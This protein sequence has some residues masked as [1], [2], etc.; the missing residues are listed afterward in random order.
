MSQDRHP[1]EL[2]LN[3]PA[4]I[5]S[6]IMF[7]WMTPLFSKAGRGPLELEDIY[8]V[9]CFDENA[10]QTDVVEK[11]WFKYKEVCSFR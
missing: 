1:H 4:R 11:N 6:R 7:S 2:P 5:Y 10:R 8:P 3:T 9:P